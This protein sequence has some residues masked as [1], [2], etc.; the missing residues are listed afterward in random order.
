M[1]LRI[2]PVEPFSLPFHGVAV[3]LDDAASKVKVFPNRQRDLALELDRAGEF[4]K[5]W[6]VPDDDQGGLPNR[7]VAV[8]QRVNEPLYSGNE[9]SIRSVPG[10]GWILGGWVEQGRSA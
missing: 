10:V 6:A 9:G 3:T 5:R 4:G 2:V 8:G 1:R 7:G